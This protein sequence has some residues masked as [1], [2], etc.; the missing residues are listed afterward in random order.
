MTVNQLEKELKDGNLSSI[1]LLYGK[2]T[3]LLENSVKKI[4]KLFGNLVDG[5]NYIKIDNSNLDNLI[6]ELQ[7]PAFGFEKKLIIVKDTDLLKKQTKKK[8]QFIIDK[9][10]KISSYINQNIDDIKEQ[11]ILIFIEE[12]IEKNNLYKEIEKIGII[13]NFEAEKLPEIAK[14]IKYICNAYSVNIDAPTLNYFIESCGTNMQDLI[15]EIRKLIEYVGKEGTIKKENIDLLSIKQFESVIFDLTDS[16]GKKNVSKALT[17]L[18]NLLYAKEPIQKILITLYNHFKKLYIVKLCEKYKKDVSENL[19]LKPN[20]TF[21]VSKYKKQSSYF[22]E[23]ELRNILFQ[24]VKLDEG[25][26]SG[27]IDLNIG[28]ES[29]ICGYCSPTA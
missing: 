8:N 7:T 3:Y 17:V 26:K 14:R 29:V 27:V 23:D 24:F 21:L 16:L 11:N 1:Y 9:I 19:K 18:K 15:N 6:P 28:L 12:D 22:S 4:K 10:E 5:L 2:E 13:C 20:Q 25:Y